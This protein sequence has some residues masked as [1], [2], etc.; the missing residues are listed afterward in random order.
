M[1]I[2]PIGEDSPT[3]ERNGKT[4]RIMLVDDHVVFRQA[5][6]VLLEQ[7]AGLR[8]YAEAATLAE[9][10]SAIGVLNGDLDLA[11]VDLDMADGNAAELIRELRAKPSGTSVLALTASCDR[12]P[13]GRCAAEVLTTAASL[14]EILAAA[15][16]LAG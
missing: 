4:G 9:A 10:R 14:D 6:A 8:V 12:L 13:E 3:G 11:I 16:Q 7:R 15:R 5:L 2:Q 1:N